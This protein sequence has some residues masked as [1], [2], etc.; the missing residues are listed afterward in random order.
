MIASVTKTGFDFGNVAENE[1]VAI[2]LVGM[3][4][5][6]LG[7]ALV[8]VFIAVLP[9]FLDWLDLVM[10][11]KA[12]EQAADEGGDEA[13]GVDDVEVA[14]AIAMV[15]QDALRPEDGSAAQRITIRRGREDSR[16]KLISQLHTLSPHVPMRKV[17][18]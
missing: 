4:I 9:K 5:V 8:S 18:R 14:V 2:S 17:E 1:G 11:R 16:W 10:R 7:L 13:N 12:E 6:F 3:T 15:L